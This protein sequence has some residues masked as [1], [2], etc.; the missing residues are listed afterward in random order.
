MSLITSTNP[1]TDFIIRQMLDRDG[2]RDRGNKDSFINVMFP[3]EGKSKIEDII[4]AKGMPSVGVFE[5]GFHYQ[6]LSSG[7][8]QMLTYLETVSYIQYKYAVDTYR[9]CKIAETQYK[10]CVA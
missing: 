9:E 4:L 3:E 10:G 7:K 5:D 1:S 2:Y 8:W 6:Y